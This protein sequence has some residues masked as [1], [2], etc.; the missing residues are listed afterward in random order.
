MSPLVRVRIAAVLLMA[1]LVSCVPGPLTSV[2]RSES[3]VVTGDP[4]NDPARDRDVRLYEESHALLIGMSEYADPNWI[5]RRF[6]SRRRNLEDVR[7]A[8]TMHGFQIYGE[9]VHLNPG[10][11]EFKQLLDGFTRRHGYKEAARLVV[12]ISG[13]GHDIQLRSRVS[14]FC[15]SDTPDPIFDP[16][17]FTE[18]AIPEAMLRGWV[19][20]IQ[21]QH[22]LFL[23]DSCFS[24]GL[25]QKSD[26]PEVPIDLERIVTRPNRV[27]IAAGASG[28]MVPPRSEFTPAFVR[29]LTTNEADV[30]RDGFV[31]GIELVRYLRTEVLTCTDNR[32]WRR[33]FPYP[34]EDQGDIV[35]ELP[36]EL[37][38][39][40]NRSVMESA[41][42]PTT[43]GELWI[44]SEETCR[45]QLGDGPEFEVRPGQWRAFSGDYALPAGEYRVVATANRDGKLFRQTA[46]VNASRRIKVRV[47]FNRE[48]RLP[49]DLEE[50]EGAEYASL[51]GLAAGSRQAQERQR[52]EL[53]RLGLPL[54]VRN[55][56]TGMVFRYVPSGEYTMGSSEDEKRLMIADIVNSLPGEFHEA[57]TEMVR[58]E[59]RRRVSIPR[60]F[61]IGKYEVTREEWE[62]L[63]GSDPEE[64]HFKFSPRRAPVESV[65]ADDCDA[66]VNQLSRESGQ[67]VGTYRLPSEEEWETACRSGTTSLLYSGDLEIVGL[68][69]GRGLNEIAWYGGNSEVRYTGGEDSVGWGEKEFD[70]SQAGI[71]VVG[72]KRANACGLHD[73]IGN[74][75]EWTS[76]IEDRGTSRVFRGGSWCFRAGDCRSAKRSWY[77]SYLRTNDIGFRVVRVLPDGG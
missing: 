43:L 36:R 46:V 47:H 74:V 42:P 54:E 60:G 76:G 32:V 11:E 38:R 67:R 48:V 19:E 63:T 41:A 24:G 49:D 53:N 23:F 7:A 75:W 18:K 33:A 34:G 37:R 10:S 73:M 77:S 39:R 25:L 15:P 59:R 71:Q 22:A 72:G 2:P 16:A 58:R 26:L 12:L 69:H 68:H 65:S 45:V 4:I 66:W 28:E 21:T 56:R 8:L 1:A 6:E 5:P 52:A 3:S 29:A 55:K 35:F 30:T 17:G 40:P 9:R 50:V 61:Y 13:H 70:F 64:T 51:G 27:M 14:Y 31:D 44:G 62:S 20:S 57:L